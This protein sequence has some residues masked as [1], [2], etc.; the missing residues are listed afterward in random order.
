[1]I[2]ARWRLESGYAQGREEPAAG[3]RRVVERTTSEVES[4]GNYSAGNPGGMREG[5]LGGGGAVGFFVCLFL[6]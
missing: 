6:F 3:P 1:M 5:A 2:R 4:V